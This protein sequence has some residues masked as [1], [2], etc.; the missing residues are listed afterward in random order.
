MNVDSFSYLHFTFFR[1][2]LGF[3]IPVGRRYSGILDSPPCS[4]LS[5]GETQG[6]GTGPDLTCSILDLEVSV[7]VIIHTLCRLSNAELAA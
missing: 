4:E 2:V 6:T 3:M 5:A 7:S 1:V